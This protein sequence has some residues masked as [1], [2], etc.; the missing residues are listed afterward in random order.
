MT[1]STTPICTGR[2]SRA[3]SPALRVW[4]CVKLF[5]A[6][7]FRAALEEKRALALQAA[8][9][10]AAVPGIVMAA[11]PQVSAVRVPPALARLEPDRGERGDGAAGRARE[12]A[13]TG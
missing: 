13:Q 2:S 8:A 7:R 1:T 11:P 5:G 4:L 3:G 12:P 10:V 9:R 6:E